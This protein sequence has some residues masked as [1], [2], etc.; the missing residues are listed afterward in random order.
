MSAVKSDGG[1]DGGDAQGPLPQGVPGRKALCLTEDA[2]MA[3]RACSFTYRFL[4][5]SGLQPE[6]QGQNRGLRM[7]LLAD[8]GNGGPNGG[9]AQGALPQRNPCAGKVLL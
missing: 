4:N 9:Y 3:A 6:S 2:A 7:T 5:V 1:L 8:E